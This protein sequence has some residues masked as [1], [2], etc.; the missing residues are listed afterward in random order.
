MDMPLTVDLPGE[1]GTSVRC[2][3]IPDG[4]Q[5]PYGKIKIPAGPH[6]KAHHLSAFFAGAQRTIDAAALVIYRDTDIPT[7]CVS[8]QT[9]FV[10]PKATDG[11]WIGGRKVELSPSTPLPP[12]E[13]L[14]FRKGTAAV[15][16]R[17]PWTSPGSTAALVWDGNKF[18]AV[19]LTITHTL[20]GTPGAALWV[21]IGSGLTNDGAFA[22]WHYAFFTA[23]AEVT[24]ETQV[25]VAGVDGPVAVG[26]AAPY[27]TY[28]VMEPP[29]KRVVLEIDDTD[30]GR[31]LLKDLAPL[32]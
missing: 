24:G 25:R 18:G 17:V 20:T 22:K 8:L 11:F 30:V 13:A 28:T 26:A 9:H 14:V 5:D 27:K 15:G 29:P 2:Y 12:G 31:Q 6:Q 19:R 16:I 10:M 21:R 3:F 1:R 7:N 4:R 32:K 23:K